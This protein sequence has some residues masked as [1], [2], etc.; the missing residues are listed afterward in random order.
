MS[1]NL[2]AV[3]EMSGILLKVR[4]CQRKNFVGEKL[5]KAVDCKL[6]SCINTGRVYFSWRSTRKK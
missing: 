5:P 2:T 1:V 4:E 3:R 6:H